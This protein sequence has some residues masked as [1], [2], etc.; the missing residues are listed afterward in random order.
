MS[1]KD[2]LLTPEQRA[3]KHGNGIMGVGIIYLVLYIIIC[4]F[5]FRYSM[6]DL[7]SLII[8]AAQIALLVFM[9]I[10]G[11]K[12]NQM[13]V[14][15]AIVFEV[16]MIVASVL[17]LLLFR[18]G[19]DLVGLVVMIFLPSDI[20]GLDKALKEIENNK[21]HPIENNDV[22]PNNDDNIII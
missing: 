20:K 7:T 4:A 13:G 14:T 11:K 10:G 16:Y 6:F 17:S 21:N 12:R 22:F 9:I 8:V 3:K 1:K 15:A 18:R 2:E 5:S 19:P